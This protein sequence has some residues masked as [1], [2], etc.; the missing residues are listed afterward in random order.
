MPGHCL[1]C[2]SHSFPFQVM[3]MVS[4]RLL[5]P[6]DKYLPAMIHQKHTNAFKWSVFVCVYF[7]VFEISIVFFK[8]YLLKQLNL[9]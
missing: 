2:V 6:A 7:N 8:I 3:L 4:A 9:L 5:S 1:C